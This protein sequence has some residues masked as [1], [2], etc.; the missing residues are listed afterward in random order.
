VVATLAVVA[1]PTETAHHFWASMYRRNA[2]VNDTLLHAQLPAPATRKEE[3]FPSPHAFREAV[4]NVGRPHLR[5]T[6]ARAPFDQ[7]RSRDWPA[8]HQIINAFHDKPGL[9][10][11]HEVEH[12]SR[13]SPFFQHHAAA[14]PGEAGKVHTPGRASPSHDA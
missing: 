13:N 3:R 4:H 5:V 1:V 14:N 2:R 10:L 8:H 6:N 12:R 11:C 7:I 9:V